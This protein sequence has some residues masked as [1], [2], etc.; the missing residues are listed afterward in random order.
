VQ[1]VSISLV[2]DDRCG[3]KLVRFRADGGPSLYSRETTFT[4][5][6]G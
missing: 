1:A 5:I 3:F 4:S 6:G 2:S